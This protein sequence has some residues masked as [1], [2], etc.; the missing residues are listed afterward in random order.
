M[1][2]HAL[3]AKLDV[4]LGKRMRALLVLLHWTG[5]V[6]L[7][8]L[9]ARLALRTRPGRARQHQTGFVL[10]A[11]PSVRLESHMK[12]EHAVADWIVCVLQIQSALQSQRE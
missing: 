2:Q 7:A 9:S 8:V 3:F 11:V 5:F 6:L 12:A 10:L 1:G 4:L